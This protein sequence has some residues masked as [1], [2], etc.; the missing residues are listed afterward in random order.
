MLK[1]LLLIFAIAAFSVFAVSCNNPSNPS[2][3]GGSTSDGGN[4][5]NGGNTGDGG[6]TVTVDKNKGIEQFAGEY[7]GI[8]VGNTQFIVINNQIK[9]GYLFILSTDYEP[10]TSPG[11]ITI[12]KLNSVKSA[13]ALTYSM[14]GGFIFKFKDD[15]SALEFTAPVDNAGNMGTFE[16]SRAAD[17]D[18]SKGIEQFGTIYKSFRMNKYVASS[19]YD[20][21]IVQY[22]LTINNNNIK[23]EEYNEDTQKTVTVYNGPVSGKAAF[24]LFDADKPLQFYNNGDNCVIHVLSYNSNPIVF[25]RQ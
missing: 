24:Y 7:K 25:K 18:S 13:D 14:D 1:K 10:N 19:G 11:R 4:N 15:K 5:G 21:G 3:G 8:V 6:T 20:E 16:L 9:N 23:L 17:F 12:E 2:N 22:T